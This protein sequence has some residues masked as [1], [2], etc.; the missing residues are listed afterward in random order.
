METLTPS[1]SSPRA[2]GSEFEVF[3]SFR[4]ED[5]RNRFIGH[6]YEGLELRGISTFIDS[7]KLEKGEEINKLLEYIERSKI[8]VPIFSQ[9]FAESKW[10]LKEVTKSVEC[11]KEIIPVF[12]GVEPSDVRNQTGPFRSAFE[13]H[14]KKL[15]QEEVRNWREALKKV[16]SLSGFTLKDMNWD[17]AKLKRAVIE[18]VSAKLNKNTFEVAKHPVG[19][20]TRVNDVKKM[21]ENGGNINGVHVV[22]IH[23]M[24]GLGKTTIAKAVYNDLAHGFNGATCFISDVRENAR[25]HNGLVNLQ[26]KFIEDIFKEKNTSLGDVDQGKI[27]IKDKA[28]GKRILLILDDVDSG[29]QLD[30]LAGGRD[31]FDSG[32]VII[33]TTRDEKVLLCCNMKVKQHEIYK[34]QELNKDE[35]LKLFM[36][37]AFND[38][39]PEGEY[40]RLSN[41]VVEAAGGLP[42]TLEV[43]GSLLTCDMDVEEWEYTLEE[44]KKIPPGKSNR[45]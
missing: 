16:G 8:F 13:E 4:G 31:W 34:P 17:E 32:S 33:I 28:S 20:E 42:L 27:V 44:L 1:P 45:G 15:N 36:H 22:G 2:G 21:L 25:Q 41:E 7:E 38:V 39:Q 14:E 19:I 40:L 29:K 12:F 24:G 6:L 11:R 9:C 3:L 37:H 26:K 18:S 10:C 35:S 23:G 30:A 5:T 43:L